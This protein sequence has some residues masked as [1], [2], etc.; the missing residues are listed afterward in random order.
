MTIEIH[1]PELQALI[2]QRMASGLFNSVED[3]LMQ[4]LESAALPASQESDDA[5]RRTGLDLLE[6]MQ[7]MPCKDV[8]IEPPRPHMAVRDV[9]L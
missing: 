4:T 5:A 1:Q 7:A 9:A 8:D 3:L 2:R 6:A